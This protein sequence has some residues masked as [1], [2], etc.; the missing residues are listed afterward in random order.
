MAAFPA[1]DWRRRAVEFQE[2]RLSLNLRLVELLVDTTA[3]RAAQLMIE[4]DP[5]PPVDSGSVAK[6]SDETMA[7]VIEYASSGRS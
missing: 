4:Y 7:R 5:Q 1:D 3:A 6:A 2:P